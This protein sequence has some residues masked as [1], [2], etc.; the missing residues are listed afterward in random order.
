M[1]AEGVRAWMR[2][3]RS[4]L[5]ALAVLCVAPRL[6]YHGL[7]IGHDYDDG[8]YHNLAWNLAHGRGFWSDVLGHSHLGEH[9]SPV[10]ALLAP[11]WL[12]W[13]SALWLMLVQGLAVAATLAALLWLAERH[14]PATADPSRRTARL[15]WLGMLLCYPPLWAAWWWDFQPL[16]LAMPCVAWGMVALERDRPR[17][18]AICVGLLLLTREAAPLA[19][20]GLAWYA[21]A[22]SRRPR[23]GIAIAVASLAV[24]LLAFVV[25]MPAARD[26]GAW[27]HV[28]RLG[29]WED[30]AGKAVYLLHL[31]G[32]LAFL[33]LLA[34]RIA[35]AAL[36][37]ALLNISVRYQ[38]MYGSAYHYDATIAPFLLAAAAVGLA[39]VRVPELRWLRCA[40]PVAVAAILVVWTGVPLG[41]RLGWILDPRGWPV[42]AATHADVVA[43][44]R[45]AGIGPAESLAADPQLGPLL[46]GRP[47]YRSLER[48]PAAVIAG[49]APGTAVVVQRWWWLDSGIDPGPLRVQVENDRIMVLRRR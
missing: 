8:I 18:L 10:I 42:A 4:V 40:L 23:I 45:S 30:P 15:L 19:G 33:P 22:V 27:G 3:R 31:V 44:M 32:W 6:A 43:A 37:M 39:R 28:S 17:L 24:L 2:R 38:P 29:P 7:L 13:P 5:V 41:W 11:L 47:G 46:A 9:F 1:D 48:D 49:L 12:L 25:V 20:F 26:G 35:I 36:P 16:V 34:P 14:L 21:W